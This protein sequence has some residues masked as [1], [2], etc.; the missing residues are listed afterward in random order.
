MIV[1]I[2]MGC[3]CMMKAEAAA[4]PYVG[5]SVLSPQNFCSDVGCC[6][7]S[8]WHSGARPS[9]HQ[10]SLPVLN[11]LVLVFIEGGEVFQVA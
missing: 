8:D 7:E 10:L 4:E 3:I 11:S 1:M 9:S 2:L 6:S 5:C